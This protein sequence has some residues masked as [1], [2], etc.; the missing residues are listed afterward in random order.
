VRLLK[1]WK[2]VPGSCEVIFAQ[3]TRAVWTKV[4]DE[5]IYYAPDIERV[6]VLCAVRDPVDIP[7]KDV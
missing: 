4:N 3:L 5:R 1:V 7:L 2:N 6:T